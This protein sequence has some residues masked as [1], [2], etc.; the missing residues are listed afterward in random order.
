ME[1][2]KPLRIFQDY[3][4]DKGIYILMLIKLNKDS[5]LYF[6]HTSISHSKFRVFKYKYI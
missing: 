3:L 4:Q 1:H 6:K 2:N 5:S